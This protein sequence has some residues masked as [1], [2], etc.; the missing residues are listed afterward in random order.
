MKSKILQ[1]IALICVALLGFS[2]M[3]LAQC[4]ASLSGSSFNNGSVLISNF[5]TVSTS[6]NNIFS[7]S[8]PGGTP[9]SA[10]TNH[11]NDS[12]TVSYPSSGTYTVCLVI[13][14][15]LT[16]CTDSICDTV[17]SASNLTASASG[18]NAS[19]GLCNGSAS[20]SVVGGAAPF[21]YSWSQGSTTSSIAALCSGTYTVTVT[22]NNGATSVAQTGIVSSG[23]ISASIPLNGNTCD[24]NSYA[25]ATTSGG[26]MPYSYLW[27]TAASTQCI[28][29][30]ISGTYT[31]T[32]TDANGCSA[33]ASTNLL[34]FPTI[35]ITESSTDETCL[36]CCDGSA[37]VSASGGTGAGFS[38]LWSTGA[39]TASIS[40]LCTGSYWVTVTDDSSGCTQNEYVSISNPCQN[41]ISGLVTPMM[42]P[43]TVYLI[44]ESAG[45]LSLV[46]SM[47]I[48]SGGYWFS[49]VC[50]G[51]YYVKAAL[52]SSSSVYSSYLPTY[53]VQSALWGSATS[54]T[55]SGVSNNNNITLL[56]G[57]NLGG[58]GFIGGLISQGANRAEGDPIVG[59]DV[60]LM[61]GN[62]ELLAST[63]SDANG[64]YSFD[65]L[66]VGEYEVM[67]DLLNF[68]PYPHTAI[69]TEEDATLS[70]K[71]FI[72]EGG[73][74]RP[75]EEGVG[76]GS[77]TVDAA[78]SVFPNPAKDVV[79]V[80]GEE[81]A[82]VSVFNLLGAQ[83][84][85]MAGSNADRMEVSLTDL[86][87]GQYIL[88]IED[89]SGK[90]HYAPVVKQ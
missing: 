87:P 2:G 3:S 44:Q 1:K 82:T 26:A 53:Y 77:F 31:V 11:I 73:I 37:S 15:T 74:V 13:L 14:D 19:C 42:E 76:I 72:V 21:T 84:Q 57:S 86:A 29:P 81:I 23:A 25:C 64:N 83:I 79:F 6:N 20:A 10:T 90:A 4:V 28:Y 75:V 9:S 35:T 65:N 78:I 5:S 67:V 43:A 54:I 33:I 7:W 60:F 69:I 39:T 8:F 55:P 85:T 68:E 32:V 51:T 17:I 61:D 27:S 38:Y 24:S 12:I 89:N 30:G 52:R 22:D 18:I 50:N 40:S 71:D 48:D 63:T 62:N 88:K 34:V 47:Q 41:T 46:D 58:P 45:V 80:E 56:T 66:P 49:N 59:A 16:N 36:G 70:T